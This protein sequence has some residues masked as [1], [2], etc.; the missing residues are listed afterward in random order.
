MKF[1]DI[2]QEK[3]EN[4]KLTVDSFIQDVSKY[5]SLDLAL[6]ELDSIYAE[7]YSDNEKI[8][9]KPLSKL[10]LYESSETSNYLGVSYAQKT[11]RKK[12]KYKGEIIL[13]EYDAE[14]NVWIPWVATRSIV[15]AIK[16][17]KAQIDG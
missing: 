5:N 11:I 4:K 17:G 15:Q 2:I 9:K 12:I 8:L 1:T 13:I 7:F 10:N 6:L 3:K 16:M 14:N